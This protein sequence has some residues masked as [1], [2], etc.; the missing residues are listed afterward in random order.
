MESGVL[1][2]KSQTFVSWFE[3]TEQSHPCKESFNG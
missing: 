1:L 3:A 2:V